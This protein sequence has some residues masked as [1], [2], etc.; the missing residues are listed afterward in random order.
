MIHHL[1][2]QVLILLLI[3]S[4]VGMVA[5]RL[6]VPYT[7]ALVVAGLGLS[8]LHLHALDDLALT[9]D[10]LLLLFLPPLLFEAAYH[11]PFEDL[12]KNA[13]HITYLA[14]AGVMVAVGLTAVLSYAGI[15]LTGAAPGYGWSTAFLF[16]AVIAATDPISVLALFK[17]MGAP[18]RLYQVV[19]G[20]SLV[21]DGVAVVV[22]TIISAVL[23]L[24][25]TQVGGGGELESAR[26]ITTFAVITFLKTGVGGLLVGGA[27]GALASVL[28]RTVDDHLIEITLTTLVAWGSFLVAETLHV[29]GVLSTV[30][31]GVLM[32]SFGK[33]Y[34]MSASTRMAVQDFWE[35]MGFLSNSFIF[36]L[37]G[38]ELEPTRLWLHLPIVLAGFVAVMVARAA[39]VYLG[40]PIADR[41]TKPLPAVWRHVLVWGGLR[42]SLSMV[43]VLGL[44]AE[45]EG[46][47]LLID[48]VFGVVSLS[49][50]VQGLTMAPL[51]RRLGVTTARGMVMSR[52]YEKARGR[53]TAFRRVLNEANHLLEQG[54]LDD[55]AH[56]HFSAYYD[57]QRQ[58]AREQAQ[59]LAGDTA[60]PEQLLE[61]ARTLGVIEREAIEAA[62]HAGV[63]S[64]GAAADLQ[65]D[66][67]RR[68]DS[69]DRAAHDGEEELLRALDSAYPVP[70]R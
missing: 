24:S 48:L 61:A 3:A 28:T 7:L 57:A 16:A 52:D 59:I 64:E 31:S 54:L 10:L 13:V 2:V 9:P 69:L 43:L 41:F 42:G 22:F 50:F 55:V 17:E 47:R 11:L 45:Y 26:E 6:G 29:N 51:M 15:H 21:N 32:G 66:L 36:L 68:L 53:A 65:S 19:E 12:R 23:G 49:L 30:A 56:R 1:E 46:R 34:G 67:H 35:Y 58:L 38:I 5:R 14:L 8:F 40:L 63:I 20:E 39:L 27:C 33:H 37:I 4:I 70:R 25:S 44:P 62:L 60:Q 18:K